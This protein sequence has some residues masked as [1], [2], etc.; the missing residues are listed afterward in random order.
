MAIER[1]EDIVAW[2]KARLLVRD[3]NIALR[4]GPATRDFRFRDQICSAA[5]SV[6]SNIAEGF[7]RGTKREFHQFLV[8]AGSSCGEVRSQLYAALDLG[9]ITDEQFRELYDLCDHTG[10]LC[11][12]FRKSLGVDRK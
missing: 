4:D 10:R 7:E 12:A 1:F 9:Y 2:Q 11:T 3:I 5:L 8:I 6:M